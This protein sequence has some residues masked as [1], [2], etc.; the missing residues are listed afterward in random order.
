VTS[1]VPSFWSRLS[2]ALS[3]FFRILGDPSFAGRVRSV[4]GVPEA[5]APP[6]LPEAPETAPPTPSVQ[7]NE[8]SRPHE[9]TALLVLSL[10]QREGRLVDFLTQDVE[11]FPDADIGAAARVVHTG[12]RRA[13]RQ[14]FDVE[15]VRSEAEGSNVT[16]AES[17]TKSVT[18]T[19]NVKGGAPHRGVLRHAGWRA[20]GVRLPEMLATHDATLICP[21][22]VEL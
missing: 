4:T 15:H 1:A 20:V 9:D 8:P 6:A 21:A 12:C 3:C 7:K 10:F 19:G 16:V 18:L 22:E 17:E 11:S 5:A 13:L 2:L 14:H